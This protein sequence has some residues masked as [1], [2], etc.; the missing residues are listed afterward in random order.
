MTALNEG[1]V[2]DLIEDPKKRSKV[3]HERPSAAR[4]KKLLEKYGAN[5][6]R[7]DKIRCIVEFNGSE[8]ES[9]GQEFFGNGPDMQYTIQYG[10]EAEIPRVI[11]QAILDTTRITYPVVPGAGQAGTPRRA[12]R[13]VP[14]FMV[15]YL[16]E[17]EV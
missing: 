12:P 15:T 5:Y 4:E 3:S 16:G 10:V 9:N 14:C 11:Y 6:H 13:T 2:E 1:V 7:F 17:V 8:S